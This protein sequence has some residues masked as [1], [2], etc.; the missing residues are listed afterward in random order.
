MTLILFMIV[1][2]YIL[3]FL[4]TDVNGLIM[5]QIL[6]ASKTSLCNFP[7]NF[8]SMT[9]DPDD[10][11]DCFLNNRSF[12]VA[13]EVDISSRLLFYSDIE[14]KTIERVRLLHQESVDTIHAGTGSVEGVFSF[15]G[16]S[17]V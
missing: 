15:K 17:Q 1:F 6:M 9:L 5:P 4:I 14:K 8:P 13:V 12:A 11:V 3:N 16:T 7:G 2:R 10:T